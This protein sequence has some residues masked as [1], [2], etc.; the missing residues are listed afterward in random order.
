M[1]RV[2]KC[3][4]VVLALAL[5]VAWTGP[6]VA[7]DKLDDTQGRIKKI[8]PD[9]NEFVLTDKNG[10]DWT[11]HV[12]AGA[13]IQVAGADKKFSDLKE[14][15]NIYVAY[16]KVNNKLMAQEVKLEKRSEADTA[17]GRIKSVAPDKHE[18]VLTSTDNKNYTFHVADDAKIQVNNK[19]NE[20]LSDLKEGDEL[21]VTYK[22]QDGKLWAMNVRAK[23]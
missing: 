16:K 20:K 15:D 2:T 11:F 8:T 12:D 4:L 13:K 1:M 18:F 21:E 9:K 22:K 7:A 6:A 3:L 10:K 17:K 19:A 23:R 5:V 14:G